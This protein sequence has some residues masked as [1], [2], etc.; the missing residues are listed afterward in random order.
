M[1]SPKILWVDFVPIYSLFISLLVSP[2]LSFANVLIASPENVIDFSSVVGVR[3][4]VLAMVGSIIHRW[5]L[6]T[7]WLRFYFSI[8]LLDDEEV[9]YFGFI[10]YEMSC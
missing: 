1:D 10:R 6:S 4:W 2:E 9:F 5:H 3:V 8:L 7:S